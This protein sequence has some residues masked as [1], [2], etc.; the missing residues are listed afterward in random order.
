MAGSMRQ[1]NQIDLTTSSGSRTVTIPTNGESVQFQFNPQQSRIGAS[2]NKAGLWNMVR[3]IMLQV[4]IEVTRA[5]GSESDPINPDMFP[6]A[7]SQIGLQCP[8]FGTL[9]D[10]NVM[11]GMLAK[12]VSEFIGGGYRRMGVN[13]QPIPVGNGVYTRFF[14]IF[15]PFSQGWNINPDH[16]SI[17]LGWLDSAIL[18][19]FSEGSATPFGISGVTLTDFSISAILETVPWPELIIP[20]YVNLRRYQQAAAAG[21]NGPILMNVGSAGSLQGVDDGARLIAMLFSHDAG[22][23]DGSGTAD[24]ISQISIGWRDQ[25]QTNFASMFFERYTRASGMQTQ[26][27]ITNAGGLTD[28]YDNKAPYPMTDN[29]L[30]TGALNDPSARYTPIVWPE[31]NGKISQLQKVKGN[32]PLDG[33]NFSAP[34]SGQFTVFD[35]ELKQWNKDRVASMLVSAGIDPNAVALKPKTGLKNNGKLPDSVTWGFP[36]SVVPIAQAAGK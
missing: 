32:Y 17:W 16:F 1:G 21:S 31:L 30:P 35:L 22:G 25:I 27:G 7:I 14:E 33:I 19:I 11:T 6:L 2:G 9:I 10:P 8:M 4:E 15:L 20:P 3:G 18:E 12:H 29:P 23:F 26:L 28:V 5:D 13:R 34:Q 24:E 36:R